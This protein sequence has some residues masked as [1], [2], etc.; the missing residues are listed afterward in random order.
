[1]RNFCNFLEL[2]NVRIVL[3][4]QP[5]FDLMNDGGKKTTPSFMEHLKVCSL[6]LFPSTISWAF[7]ISSVR[8][9]ETQTQEM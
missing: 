4:A 1:M 5:I 6:F 9:R 3:S 8:T 2:L 7:L